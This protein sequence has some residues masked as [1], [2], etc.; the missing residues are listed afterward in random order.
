MSNSGGR[1]G[2]IR[3]APAITGLI[4]VAGLVPSLPAAAAASSSAPVEVVVQ[5]VPGAEPSAEASAVGLGGRIERRL[6]IIDGFIARMPAGNVALLNSADGVRSASPDEPLHMVGQYGQGSGVAS[7]VYTDVTRASKVWGSGDQGAGVN[8]AVID[9]GVST[10]G[11]LAGRVVHAEDFTT[12]QNNQ[13]SYGHGTFVAG[14]IAGTGAA[15]AGA[16]MGEAPAAGIVSLKIAGAD[17]TT[18]VTRVLEALEWVVTFKDVYHIRVVN[19]SFG[20]DGKQSYAIDPLDFAVERVW[21]DGIVVLVAAGNGGNLPGTISTPGDDPFVI[22][23]GAFNDRTTVSPSDD[24]VST[25]SSSGPTVDGFAKPDVLADGRSV[26]S[27]RSVGSTVDLANPTS[28][29]A[30]SY[31]RGSGTSFS[32]AIVSG[33]VALILSATPSLRPN[34][35]KYLLMSTARSLSGGSTP[36]TGSGE[37]DAF[38]ST[39]SG[40]ASTPS[41]NQ[42]LAP[43]QGGGSLQATRG[44]YCVRDQT[45]VCMSDQDADAL[46]GFNESTY[47][48]NNWAGSQWAGSQWAGSQWAG[49]GWQG[50]QWAGSQWAGSQ[51]AGSQWAGSQWATSQWMMVG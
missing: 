32:T 20:T 19:L 33:A 17:G 18:D 8:V 11:D 10:A 1:L 39:M 43:A 44:S 46:L 15:S 21:N 37:V 4:A 6:N 49:S 26:V 24:Y 16:I 38:A 42:G 2:W 41:A 47:F 28:A 3:W 50:S 5:A 22:T 45:G 23:V 12:E 36:A 7:A 31:A 48:S 40:A 27:S 9:T 14:L 51:W 13:D 35:V 34:Q 25:F 29:I 30:P